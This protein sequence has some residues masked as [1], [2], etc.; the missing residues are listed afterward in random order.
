MSN[1][2]KSRIVATIEATE[3]PNKESQRYIERFLSPHALLS[4]GKCT[5][6]PKFMPCFPAW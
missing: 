2:E 5:C 6:I 4:T 1:P 3:I